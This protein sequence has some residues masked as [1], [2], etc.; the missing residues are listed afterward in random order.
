M[1]KPFKLFSTRPLPPQ[2]EIVLHK[3]KPHVR[4]KE[5]GRSVLCPLTQDGTK[6][7]KPSKCWYFKVR[8]SNG[9]VRRIKGFADLKA[10]EQLAANMARRSERVRAGYLDPTDEQIRRPLHEHLAGYAAALQAKGDT[11]KHIRETIARCRALFEG[12]GFVYPSDVDAGRASDWLN[13]LR[14]AKSSST[15]TLPQGDAFTP[16]AVARLLG[17]SLN[18][19]S[20]MIRRLQLPATGNGKARRIPRSTVEALIAH[21]VKGCGPTTINHYIRA[22]RGFF[23]W[24]VRSKR[25]NTNPLESLCLLNANV[26]VRRR[27]RA[28]TVDELHKLF[29]VTQTSTRLYRG[30]SGQDRYFLYLVAAGTGFRASALAHLTPNDFDLTSPYP[31][32]TLPARW[33]KNRKTQVQPLPADVAE[34]LSPYLASKP[35]A[36]PIWAGHGLAIIGVQKC[37]VRICRRRAFRMWSKVLTVPSMPIST[38]CGIRI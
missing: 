38:V 15:I 19:V 4:L 17:V 9:V 5:R 37:C 35:S 10:T 18:A 6:M 20:A 14:H 34:A 33:S 29:V 1:P 11:A 3:G 27:R 21:R 23:R 8:D 7:L 26:D 31:S 25:L 24:L 16:G 13:S 2:A 32:V 22:V 12:C 36:I 28:L 30:L